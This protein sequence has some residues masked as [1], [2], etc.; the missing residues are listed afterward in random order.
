MTATTLYLNELSSFRCGKVDE[1]VDEHSDKPKISRTDRLREAYAQ[2]GTVPS[3]RAIIL[4][5]D[6]RHPH[7]FLLRRKSDG[8]YLLPGG[9]LHPGE[10]YE[11]GLTRVLDKRLRIVRGGNYTV[12]EQLVATWYRP[13]FTDQMFPYL[14]VH[15]HSPKEREEW[16]IVQLPE[17][18]KL[19]VPAKYDL[20]CARFYDLQDGAA[21]FGPQLAMVPVL[22]SRFNF[23]LKG[24]EHMSGDQ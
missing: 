15:I 1:Y 16:Y 11:S 18:A 22:M 14:P 12:S 17:N 9:R 4:A 19:S 21:K 6:H 24:D 20:E 10:D 13:Q 8:T 5:L 7:I 3:V 2:S 23:E